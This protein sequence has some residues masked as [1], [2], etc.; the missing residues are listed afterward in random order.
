MSAQPTCADRLT[1]AYVAPC[2]HPHACTASH[3]FQSVTPKIKCFTS[4]CQ[5]ANLP[6]SRAT[7]ACGRHGLNPANKTARLDQPLACA[8]S[9]EVRRLLLCSGAPASAA[10]ISVCAHDLPRARSLLRSR[11]PPLSLAC[12]HI[13]SPPCVSIA[14]SL[15]PPPFITALEHHAFCSRPQLIS[16]RSTLSAGG[17]R[18]AWHASFARAPRF[19]LACTRLLTPE[20]RAVQLRAAS[21]SAR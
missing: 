19:T 15:S 10:P 4:L 6:H 17:P 18:R 1:P 21:A 14:C 11:A 20:N 13:C 9:H 7:P 2:S 5:S 3:A 8:S 12:S 16:S